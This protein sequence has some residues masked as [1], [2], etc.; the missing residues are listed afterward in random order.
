MAFADFLKKH[1]RPVTLGTPEESI[2]TKPKRK[3]K[4]RQEGALR[5]AAIWL[6]SIFT[7]LL[8]FWG[9]SLHLWIGG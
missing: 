5:V 8:F 9:L 7:A 4:E 6:V 1:K 2:A 3:G